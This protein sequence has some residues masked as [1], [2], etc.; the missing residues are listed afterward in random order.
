MNKKNHFPSHFHYWKGRD[1][2]KEWKNAL[3]EFEYNI[4]LVFISIYFD[5]GT[6][7]SFSVQYVGKVLTANRKAHL[8]TIGKKETTLSVQMMLETIQKLSSTRIQCADG[9]HSLLPIDIKGEQLTYNEIP[10]FI[11]ESNGTLQT[12]PIHALAIVTTKKFRHQ[13]VGLINYKFYILNHILCNQGTIVFT[14]K[15]LMEKSGV[16]DRLK[17]ARKDY[18]M[19]R[20]TYTIYKKRK[21]QLENDFLQ[22]SIRANLENLKV[23]KIIKHFKILKNKVILSKT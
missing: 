5:L 8:L 20:I 22:E 6:N 3:S 23:L 18:E 13:D 10:K 7:R 2:E 14:L 1:R 12:I 17:I 9:I 4:F 15:E 16:T 19:R 21:Y 11:S